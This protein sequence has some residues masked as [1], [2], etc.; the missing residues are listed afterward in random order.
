MKKILPMI[1]LLSF[2]LPGM[3]EEIT[4][5]CQTTS[6]DG[7]HYREI[8]AFD[9]AAGTVFFT[10]SDGVKRKIPTGYITREEFGSRAA[11]ADGYNTRISRSTG[12]IQIDDHGR[13][14]GSGQCVLF[15][16]AF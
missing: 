8:M 6:P 11:D 5:E 7:H 12:N 15:K 9:E 2:S 3:A 13:I 14:I 1:L 16:Q 10:S 4:L